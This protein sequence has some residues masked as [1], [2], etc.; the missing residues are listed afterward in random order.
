MTAEA[1]E[2]LLED[3]LESPELSW[4]WFDLDEGR[5]WV[6]FDGGV[7]PRAEE[8]PKS[9]IEV[10]ALL[11]P[12][13]PSHACLC[14]PHAFLFMTDFCCSTLLGRMIDAHPNVDVIFEPQIV[15]S[16]AVD[17]RRVELDHTLDGRR[18]TRALELAVARLSRSTGSAPLTVI[19]EQPL[20]NYIILDLLSLRR[21]TRA[22]AIHAPLEEY[23]LAVLPFPERCAYTRRRV[24]AM[25]EHS[26]LFPLHETSVDELEDP[27]VCALHWLVQMNHFRT[28][29]GAAPSRIRTVTAGDIAADPGGV[30]RAAL[31]FF[32]VTSPDDAW[33]KMEERR[34]RHSKAPGRAFDG[35]DRA[36]QMEIRRARAGDAIARG[37]A[38]ARARSGL[39]DAAVPGRRLR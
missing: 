34:P 15:V 14:R 38:W 28:A 33:A 8:H 18:W 26:D 20:T 19:K 5:L 16:L 36:A 35:A 29:I 7:G 25:R 2:L 27:E 21:D 10:S 6:D 24:F 39:V 9:S 1:G 22:L 37:L 17:R 11:D 30:G 4:R 3:A 32:G 13:L 31:A 12:T 23:L